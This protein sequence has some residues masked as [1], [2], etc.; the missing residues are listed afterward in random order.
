MTISIISDPDDISVAWLNSVFA[1]NGLGRV[2]DFSSESI[3]TGQV[4]ENVR[5]KLT[6]ADV[7]ESVVGKFPSLD[8][9]SRQTG[10]AQGN[11]L[12]EVFHLYHINVKSRD[13]L[14]KFLINNSV[15]AKIHYPIPIHL[16]PAAKYLKHKRGDFPLAEKMANTSIS[17]PVHEFIKKNDIKYVVNLINKFYSKKINL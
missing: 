12:K 6:G 3:G 17:L 10:I 13:K 9:V 8:P 7:P 14:Q 16:Q 4:G 2:T 11:Y 15:D 5:F 1:S